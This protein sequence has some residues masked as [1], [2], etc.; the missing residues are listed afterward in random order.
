[1]KCGISKLNWERQMTFSVGGGD[2]EGE[3]LTKLRKAV[4]NSLISASE[5]DTMQL[6]WM[7]MGLALTSTTKF[8]GITRT[9]EKF[10]QTT[11]RCF[12]S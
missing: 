3:Y 6:D 12:K 1:M 5:A 4:A 9:R 2:S 11:F 10:Q 8:S 7:Q